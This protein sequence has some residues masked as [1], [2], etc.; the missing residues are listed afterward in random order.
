MSGPP[1]LE[2]R[3][4]TVTAGERRLCAG[5]NWAVRPGECWAV[6]GVNGAGKTS[7]LHTLAGLRRAAAG[8]VHLDGAPLASLGRRQIARRLGI[9]FQDYQDRFPG[10]VW[11]TAMTGR[12]PHLAPWQWEG[13]NDREQVG[14]ALAEVGL[15]GFAHREIG[16]LSGGERRRLALAT[17]LAQAP[18]LYLLD[19]P[20]NHLDLHHQIA[21]LA[22]VR[23]RV[24][25]GAGAVLVLHDLNLAARFCD[26]VCLL[27]GAGETR[28]GAV[29]AL[30]TPDTL[31][32]LYAHPIRAVAGPDGP[33]YYP[34]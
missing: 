6:L 29:E 34:A 23:R 18:A 10:T 27:L 2:A 19:E 17:V 4:L 5:L 16:T 8:E 28:L 25:A 24:N 21:M 26:R 22:A 30:F 20:V 9:L 14:A 13:E 3:R 32:R 7:L 1:L 33:L 11:D 31:S 12:L 15:E